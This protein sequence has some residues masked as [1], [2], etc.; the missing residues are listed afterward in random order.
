MFHGLRGDALKK[1]GRMPDAEREYGE[2][3]RRN[4]EYYAFYLNRG[5]TRQRLGNNA[6][7]QSDLE[8]SNVL[9]PT[10]AAHYVLGNLAQGAG[11]PAKAMEHY[12]LAA[13]SDSDVG[14]RA[15]AELVRLDL[16]RNP[17]NYVEV[18][19]VADGKG[20]LGLRLTNSSPVA[21]RNVRVAAEVPK[22]A[23]TA[24]FAR[25]YAVP[26]SLKAGQSTTLAMG[27]KLSDFNVKLKQVRGQV[28]GAEV[29]E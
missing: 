28:R 12:K 1:L 19:P 3:I 10:A 22:T 8:R 9:L 29:A 6:G 25:E 26:G 2:A 15:G 4:S 14:K 16:P 27:V 17:G 23:S 7:A 20:N 11:S 5:L 21:L 13:G 18:E 24:R